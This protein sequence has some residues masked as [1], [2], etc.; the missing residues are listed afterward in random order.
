MSEKK[1]ICKSDIHNTAN[2][3]QISEIFKYIERNSFVCLFV[4]KNPMRTAA[5]LSVS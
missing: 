4:L 5:G 2:F 1:I 3:R